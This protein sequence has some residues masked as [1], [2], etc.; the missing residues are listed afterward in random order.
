MM[1]KIK[2]TGFSLVELMIAMVISLVL[3]FACTSVYSSLQASLNVAKD[4]STAQESLRTAHYL[5]A[6]SV[7]QGYGMEVKVVDGLQQLVIT[8]GSEADDYNFYGCLGGTQASGSTDTFYVKDNYLYCET[9][10]VTVVSGAADTIAITGDE[11]IALDVAFMSAALATGTKKGVEVTL[12]I[13]GMPTNMLA[14]GFTFSLAM[15]QRIII[16][17]ATAGLSDV[18]L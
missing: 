8:Y 18:S 12:G 5:M 15:R 10:T 3:I 14:D 13:E 9:A 7:R 16:D 17:A 1:N 2:Q 6:R 4:L 11:P